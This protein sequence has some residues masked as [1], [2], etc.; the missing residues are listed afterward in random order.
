MIANEIE[1]RYEARPFQPFEVRMA[2]GTSY[3]IEHPHWMLITPNLLTLHFVTREGRSRYLA[4]GHITS[5]A[6]VETK[7]RRK[8]AGPKDTSN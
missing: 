7:N 3:V 5:V 2:D 1:E 4:M 8:G 6:P